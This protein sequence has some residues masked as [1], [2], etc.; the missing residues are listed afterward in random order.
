MLLGASNLTFALSTLVDDLRRAAGGPVEVLAACGRGR[1]YGAWSHLLFVRHL[2][3]IAG[4][5]LWPALNDRP[6]LPTVALV[7]DVGNDLG[8]G[9]TPET[10]AGWIE[11]CLGRLDGLG[12][13]TVCTL[14]PL[15][16]IEQL[17][18]F[19]Y[20]AARSILFPGRT[21]SRPLLLTRA[22]AMDGHLRRLAREHAAPLIEPDAS[23]YGIDPIHPKR[24]W[25]R[26][27]WDL[28]LAA[29]PLPRPQPAPR[30]RRVPLPLCGE[31]EMRFF[32]FERRHA[33][34]VCRLA[35]GTTVA[36]Y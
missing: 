8:Y 14:P 7:T 16:R 18:S 17:S 32:R 4:C 10:I 30:A 29:W 13:S 25:R 31:E 23:W 2:P 9:E 5:G 36:L 34:P 20:Y 11:T 26:Q 19:S 24:R 35:D 33:Q 1:S 22:R 27:M 15:A 3:G 28:V 21:V 12:A 6:P